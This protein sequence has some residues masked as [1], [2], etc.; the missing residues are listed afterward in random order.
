MASISKDKNGTKRIVFIDKDGHR[1]Y[2]RLGK[3]DMKMAGTIKIHVEKLVAAQAKK[4][5]IDPETARWLADLPDEFY[6]KLAKTGIIAE[7]KRVGTLVEMIP[8]IIKDKSVG[9][10]PATVEIWRQAEQGLYRHFGK[11]RR[12]DDI[13]ALEAKEYKVW[14]VKHGSLKDSGPLKKATVAK[15]MQHALSFFHAMVENEVLPRNP[16][17]GLAK[18]ATVDIKRNR[19]I[20]EDTILK[21]MEYAPDAEWRLIIAL[22]RFAGLRAAS[23]VLSLRW[24]DILWDQKKIVVRSPKTE[25]HADQEERIIPF[26]PHIEECLLDAAEQAEDGA[27]YVVEKHAPLYLRGKKERTYISRQ[28]NLGTVFAEI[29]RRAGLTPWPKLLQNLRASFETDLLNGKYGQFGIHVIAAWLGHSP[30]V[31]LEHYARFQQGDF[32]QIAEA[33][34][35]VRQRKA[36]TMGNLE[37]HSVP[38]APCAI[39]ENTGSNAGEGVAQKAAQYTAAGGVLGRHEA[40]SPLGSNPRSPLKTRHMTARNGK[41]RPLTETPQITEIESN[42]WGG[43]RTHGGVA[44]T[45]VFKTGPIVHSGTHPLFVRPFRRLSGKTSMDAHPLFPHTKRRR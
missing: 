11:D 23:E 38:F 45:P 6:T 14:L 5:S 24:E 44:P 8:Q 29:I 16:F 7:R 30:K 9:A 39:P 43:I 18:K 32:D 26:F 12:V 33:C 42:G 21:V 27:V 31:M 2:I 41:G 17:K 28:G 40:E 22:W 35:Q 13:T 37:A 3:I 20:D 4:V 19:H 10:K 34:L 1:H 15:R 25:H 36:Q